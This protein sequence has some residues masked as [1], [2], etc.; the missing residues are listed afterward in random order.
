M[1]TNARLCRRWSC[2]PADVFTS[3]LHIPLVE[4]AL[5]HYEEPFHETDADAD[6]GWPCVKSDVV[7][8]VGMSKVLIPMKLVAT[9]STLSALV[10]D[11]GT[12]N[13]TITLPFAYSTP[14][15]THAGRL[16]SMVQ[17]HAHVAQHTAANAPKQRVTRTRLDKHEKLFFGNSATQ[18]PEF[19]LTFEK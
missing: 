3:V 7:F 2:L 16:K 1:R 19:H 17:Y 4:R 9:C 14:C 12:G 10:L 8:T 6:G 13:D 11:V 15:V 18:T 5:S